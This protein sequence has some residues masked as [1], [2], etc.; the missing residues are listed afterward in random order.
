MFAQVK[1][2]VGEVLVVAVSVLGA[3]G[4][5]SAGETNSGGSPLT[6]GPVVT[7]SLPAATP[8]VAP[9]VVVTSAGIPEVVQA[10]PLAARQ[11]TAAGAEAFV[12]YYLDVS[13]RM[14]TTP[15]PGLTEPLSTKDCRSC[16]WLNQD[17]RELLRDGERYAGPPTGVLAIGGLEGRP[18]T[19]A[20]Y[21][22]GV[23]V[24]QG[25]Y[26]IVDQSGRIIQRIP[27]R[28]GTIVLELKWADDS[29]RTDKIQL[30]EAGDG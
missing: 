28:E 29:W 15:A 5:S 21:S 1:R 13:N 17:A 20:S 22:V 9:S 27:S 26:P 8:V 18:E 12:R 16:N 19:D 25:V 23:R 10:I 3:V 2:V 4:C 7:P 11:R 14:R 30:L 6:A 24:R